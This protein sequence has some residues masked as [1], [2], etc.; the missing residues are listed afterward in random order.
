MALETIDKFFNG[1][2][3]V[4]NPEAI[5]TYALWATRGDGPALYATPTPIHVTVPAHDPTYIVCYPLLSESIPHRPSDTFQLHKQN[6][7]G[8]FRSHFVVSI[9]CA[10]LK[11]IK[12]SRH[13]DSGFP[14]GA[15]GMTAMAVSVL[16]HHST[17]H[18]TVLAVLQIERGFRAYHTGIK[19]T[20][21][22][23]SREKVA[24]AVDDYVEG[25][26]GELGKSRRSTLLVL[27][28]HVS[29]QVPVAKCDLSKIRRK[30]YIESSSPLKPQ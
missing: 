15:L 13:S 14:E 5:K 21:E 1:A 27:W 12:A 9:M 6:P 16:I 18:F 8:I 7:S 29:E 28:G 19:A 22:Q 17:L 20:V 2:G 25:V 26:I 10:F 30:L 4:N 24:D 23:F 3:F 11:S